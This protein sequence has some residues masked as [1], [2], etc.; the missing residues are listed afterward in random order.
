ML[1]LGSGPPSASTRTMARKESAT[2]ASTAGSAADH[3]THRG[4]APETSETVR[5]GGRS[6]GPE[7][8]EVA[9][10]RVP[11]GV[12]GGWEAPDGDAAA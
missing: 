6:D 8:R 1:G 2:T 11:A 10:G 9:A 3:R 7:A 12:E 5:D 4:V